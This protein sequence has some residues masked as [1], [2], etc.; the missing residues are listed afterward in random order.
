MMLKIE[1]IKKIA[2]LARIKI[3][4]E[5]GLFYAQEL[6]KIFSVIDQL[7]E[8]DTSGVEPMNSVSNITLRQRPDVISNEQAVDDV[9]R[10]APA[11]ELNYFAVPKVIE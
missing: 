2:K 8:V 11:K 10:N 7:A 1:E 6:S 3:S 5:E 9:L 4:E